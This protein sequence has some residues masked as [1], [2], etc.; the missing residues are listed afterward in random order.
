MIISNSSYR[1]GV[2]M[3]WKE[4]LRT[5]PLLL[6]VSYFMAFTSHGEQP[7]FYPE[8]GQTISVTGEINKTKMTNFPGNTWEE[9]MISPKEGEQ[10]IVIGEVAGQLWNFDNRK[11]V[12]LSGVLKPKMMVKGKYI[13]VIEAHSIDKIEDYK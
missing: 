6:L 3:T 8:M 7:E 13:K 4:F 5:V 11:N 9:L 12:T 2:R 1:L 10:Y